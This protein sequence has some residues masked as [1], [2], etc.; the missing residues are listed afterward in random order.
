MVFARAPSLVHQQERRG[1]RRKAPPPVRAEAAGQ[2]GVL[3]NHPEIHADLW[4][5]WPIGR[6]GCDIGLR[7]RN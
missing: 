1:C 2:G 7:E 6:K 4:N 3:F 5:L